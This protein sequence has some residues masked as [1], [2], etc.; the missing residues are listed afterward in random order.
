ME[1]E[2]KLVAVAT[3][4]FRELFQSSNPLL[5]EEALANVETTISDQVNTNLTA[6]VSEW[7]VKSAIFTM[8]PEKAPGPD[9]FTALFYQKFW[10]IVKNDLTHMVN[11]FLFNG[12]M[13][14]GLNDAN[15]GL[16]PKKEKPNEMS[17]FQIISKVI[18][19]SLI[20]I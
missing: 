1:E 11:E 6:H 2:E 5:I 14:N 8:H 18:C 13:A 15:I 20:H 16:I 4:Y 10:D 3:S 9:G 12:I 19:L 7:E 17:Q